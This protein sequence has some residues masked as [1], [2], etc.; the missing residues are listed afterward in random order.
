MFNISG[1][2]PPTR[3]LEAGE[4]V[5]TRKPIGGI[6]KAKSDKYSKDDMAQLLVGYTVVPTRNWRK[7]KQRQH[8][9]Y[10]KSDGRFVRGGFITGFTDGGKL[11]TVANGFN[12]HAK[13]YSA[14]AA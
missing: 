5:I 2:A 10:I 1:A 12:P 11:M 13:G 9:R 7:L 6:A 3:K 8:I 14:W 4:I